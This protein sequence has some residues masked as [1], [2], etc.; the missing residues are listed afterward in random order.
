MKHNYA[1][2]NKKEIKLTLSP[3][4][5]VMHYQDAERSKFASLF[6][7]QRK[8]LLKELCGV[9]YGAESSNFASNRDKLLEEEKKADA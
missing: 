5:T 2:S 8:L 6:R 1:D 7:K 9:L 4:M 3:D